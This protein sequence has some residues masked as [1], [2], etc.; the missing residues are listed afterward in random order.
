LTLPLAGQNE[1]RIDSLEAVLAAYPAGDTLAILTL[2]DLW[3]NTIN[4]DQPRAKAYARRI[5]RR[6]ESL[7][8]PTGI[9]TGHQR[10]G[11]SY[12]YES[13][14]DST[15]FHYRRA[16]ALYDSLGWR[17]LQGV[18]LFNTA[19]VHKDG[20]R[21]DS[22]RVYLAMADERFPPDSGYFVQRSAVNTMRA[23]IERLE[24]NYA[25]GIAHAAE[26]Y[27]LAAAAQD[28]SRM[29]DAE[30]EI[31]FGYM[32]MGDH[33]TA[34]DY[35]RRSIALYDRLEDDYYGTVS[36]INLASTLEA[37]AQYSEAEEEIRTALA[38][39]EEGGF[40]DLLYDVYLVLGQ[41]YKGAGRLE[42]AAEA[43]AVAKAEL[44]P[45]GDDLR[46]AD[47]YTQLAELE[48]DRDRIEAARTAA[49]R[50]LEVSEP[51]GL[52]EASEA[53]HRVLAR[54]A[55]RS[56]DYATAY[57]E[58]DAYTDLR[59]SLRSSRLTQQVAELTARFEREKQ[60]RRIADQRNRLALLESRAQ[61]DRLQKIGL[62]V[63]IFVLLLLLGAAI[64]VFRQRQRR[65][66]AERERLSEQLIGHQ[67]ELSAHALHLTQ[68]SRLL[69]Q[70]GDELQAIR[71]ERPNDRKK[72]N[73]LVRD[74][75]SEDR[76][77]QDWENFRT[78]FQGVHDGFD[79]RLQTV[80]S[81][82]L[83]TREQRLA[84]LIKMQLTNQEIGS[85]LGISQDTLYK[86]KYRLRKKLPAAGEG[87]LDAYIREL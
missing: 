65:Q 33:T 68:K 3:R 82:S 25:D 66:R 43:L 29:A 51:L 86:A 45:E 47:L 60:D 50:V 7:D 75:S 36:R 49:R 74:I 56:G 26:S 10:L 72:L 27:R 84:A 77:D 1:A 71:G 28:S 2:V 35:F 8:Y 17:W 69:D 52:V 19:I 15:L 21:H 78:Y 14:I 81:P 20:G 46:T 6:S 79:D 57:R 39:V 48:L 58:L 41:V 55:A 4:T 63:G 83:S 64:Y 32:D 53:A 24:G 73:G 37:V 80:A 85:I 76:I 31:A 87:G 44:L 34:A 13:R 61:V 59:D 11:I 38:S 18:M 67:R 62:W 22:A 23:T 70:L 16:L 30:Q 9:A 40:T 42:G 12:S 5:I 54:A